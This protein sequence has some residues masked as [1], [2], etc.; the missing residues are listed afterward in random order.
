MGRYKIT[1][2]D[3][4][5]TL[6]QR[7]YAKRLGIDIPPGQP[8]TMGEI[9]DLIDAAQPFREP[10][11]KMLA[12]AVDLGIEVPEGANFDQVSKMLDDRLDELTKAA[13]RDNPLLRTGN[14]ISYVGW[15]YTIDEITINRRGV[16]TVVLVPIADC[17]VQG[18]RKV[19]VPLYKLADCQEPTEQE[20]LMVHEM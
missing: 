11:D 13:F 10:T 12:Y 15:P 18:Y 17:K 19:S 2:P 4:P 8:I 16:F 6:D 7:S 1:N 5:A 9:S 20:L 3:L 14:T